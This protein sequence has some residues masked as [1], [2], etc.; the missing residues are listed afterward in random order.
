MITQ[1]Q[2]IACV[3]F[4]VAA[5]GWAASGL[6]AEAE[7][8]Q[9]DRESDSI[10]ISGTFAR[11]FGD[12]PGGSDGDARISYTLTTADKNYWVLVFDMDRY[13]PQDGVRAF[14]RRQVEVTGCKLPDGRLL[15]D[16]ITG[17]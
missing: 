2:S 15:V 10:V 16:S 6:T 5:L 11:T 14:H 9:C 13:W 4:S 3:V 8:M 7:V 12:P 17:Q 1:Y